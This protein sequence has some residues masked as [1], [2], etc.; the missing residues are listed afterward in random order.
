M[1]FL[2]QHVQNIEQ[3]ASSIAQQLLEEECKLVA[4]QVEDMQHQDSIRHHKGHS[5]SM[6]ASSRAAFL[7][8]SLSLVGFFFQIVFSYG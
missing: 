2:S 3:H 8:A 6:L 1:L 5:D 7:Q 4:G